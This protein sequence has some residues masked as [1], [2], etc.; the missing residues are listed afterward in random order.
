MDFYSVAVVC[1]SIKMNFSALFAI[2]LAIII[3]SSESV[4]LDSLV[5]NINDNRITGG[6]TAK[7][8]QFPYQVSLREKTKV[9]GTLGWFGHRCGGSIISSRWILTSAD[10]TTRDVS[11]TAA[12]LGAYHI[13]NDGQVY[14]L[15]KAINHPEYDYKN[16]HNDLC[17]VRTIEKIR[18]SPAVRPIP[19]RKR[20]VED[21]LEATVSGWGRIRVRK[22]LCG[23]CTDVLCA[24]D[25]N[26]ARRSL[27]FS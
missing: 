17:L 12:V 24:L 21:G 2:I 9:N 7:F 8:N 5:E 18:W 6:E 16:G 14:R 23:I 13:Q 26:V 22:K 1:E 11:E 27:H 10:C 15:D 19:L 20:V 25:K 3:G 4:H